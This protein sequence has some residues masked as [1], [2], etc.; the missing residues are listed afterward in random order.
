MKVIVIFTLLLLTL[1]NVVSY[2]AGNE[3]LQESGSVGTLP[4]VI[5]RNYSDPLI[6]SYSDVMKVLEAYDLHRELAP[7]AQPRFRVIYNNHPDQD[8]DKSKLT[9]SLSYGEKTVDIPLDDDQSFTFPRIEAALEEDAQLRLNR[10]KDEFRIVS[11][12]HGPN[13]PV[14]Q[15]FNAEK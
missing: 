8:P 12:I 7:N 13:E 4:E 11:D 5:V 2:A 10:N 6:L 1:Q 15:R 14:N 9:L 3:L